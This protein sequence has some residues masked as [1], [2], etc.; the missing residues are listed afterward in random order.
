[1]TDGLFSSCDFCRLLSVMIIIRD[2]K[3]F[4]PII[5]PVK[6]MPLI[7]WFYNEVGML[8]SFEDWSL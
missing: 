7:P 8:S 6:W 1:M 5:G 2:S 4:L 3:A